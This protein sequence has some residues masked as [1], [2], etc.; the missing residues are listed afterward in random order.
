DCLRVRAQ[1]HAR[2]NVLILAAAHDVAHVAT[3]VDREILTV[4]GRGDVA[5]R[6]LAQVVRREASRG[7]LCLAVPRWRL[8]QEAKYLAAFD[9]LKS[10]GYVFL[11]V[12]DLVGRIRVPRK[13][14]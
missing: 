9:G 12:R 7:E 14:N 2:E 8:D 13:L 6:M 5:V 4:G 11:E 10:G 3:E 1:R